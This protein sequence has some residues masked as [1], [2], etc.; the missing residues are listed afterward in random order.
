MG[1]CL[2]EF[3]VYPASGPAVSRR[4]GHAAGTR[5][6]SVM[7]IQISPSI[8]CADFAHLADEARRF[9]TPTGSTST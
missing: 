5:M 3:D 6:R 4:L 1:A 7:G 9:R 2:C 8:L